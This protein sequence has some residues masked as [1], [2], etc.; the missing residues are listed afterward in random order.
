MKWNVAEFE[1]LAGPEPRR[2]D[3]MYAGSLLKFPGAKAG[4]TEPQLMIF[5]IPAPDTNIKVFIVSLHSN[6]VWLNSA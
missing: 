5:C 4:Y 2:D 1:P 6:Y 3:Y